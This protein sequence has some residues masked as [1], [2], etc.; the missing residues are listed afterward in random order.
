[1]DALERVEKA[2]AAEAAEKAAASPPRSKATFNLPADM[3]DELRYI[4][5]KYPDDAGLSGLAERALADL[6]EKLRAERNE[7]QRFPAPPGTRLRTPSPR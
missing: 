7:G 1:M 6:L 4:A 5:F 3:L 2:E